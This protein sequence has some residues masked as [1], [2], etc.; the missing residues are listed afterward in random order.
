MIFYILKLRLKAAKDKKVHVNSRNVSTIL[1]CTFCDVESDSSCFLAYLIMV[2]G[3]DGIRPNRNRGP[4]PAKP[5]KVRRG[6]HNNLG[7][8]AQCYAQVRSRVSPHEVSRRPLVP[9]FCF[10]SPPP[11]PPGSRPVRSSSSC[12]PAPA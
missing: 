5:A 9:P 3:V 8:R 7:E 6:R 2:I 11:S 4:V 12:L 10:L 1:H